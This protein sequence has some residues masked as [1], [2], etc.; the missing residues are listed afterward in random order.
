[1]EI[2]VASSN[3]FR[4]ELSSFI[5]SEA[6]YTVHEATD[7]TTLFRCLQVLRPDLIVLDTRLGGMHTSDIA[8]YVRQ[9]GQGV[10]IVL[11]TNT[12]TRSEFEAGDGLLTWPYQAEELL[13]RVRGLLHRPNRTGI[14]TTA[15]MQA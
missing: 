1:M 3:L 13:S 5:L 4:R 9:H 6:G 7:S 2:I 8:R 14:L 15:P 10:P 11:L 12:T